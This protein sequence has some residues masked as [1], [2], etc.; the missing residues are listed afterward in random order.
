MFRGSERKRRRMKMRRG[1]RGGGA[2]RGRR[3]RRREGGG[4]RGGRGI[5]DLRDV[6][7]T[8]PSS[9]LASQCILLGKF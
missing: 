2:R 3:R 5:P 6:R 1:E 8:N 7:Q 9:F 4:R